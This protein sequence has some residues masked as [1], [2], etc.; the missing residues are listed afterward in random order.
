MGRTLLGNVKGE[1]GL[2]GKSAYQIWLDLGNVGSEQEF[3]D[4]LSL[5]IDSKTLSKAWVNFNGSGTVAIRSS[6]NVSSITDVGTGSYKIN[7]SNQMNDINYVSHVIGVDDNVYAPI[8]Y[9][10]G[11]NLSNR[12]I[13]YC[14]I[15]TSGLSAGYPISRDMTVVE[16]SVFGN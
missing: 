11:E 2:N 16:F 8:C 13:N 15:R 9:E 5:A 7:F 4:Y 10:T 6:H 12:T 14:E 3:I 1:N